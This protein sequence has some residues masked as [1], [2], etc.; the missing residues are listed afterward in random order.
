MALANTTVWEMRANGDATNGGGFYDRDP[1]TSVDYSQ[2]DAAELSLTDLACVAA[3]TTLTSATGGFTAAMAGNIV[4]I[5]SGT[6]ALVGWYEITAYSDTNTVTI[7][8]TCASGGD[9]SAASG[10]VGGAYAF[11]GSNEDSYIENCWCAGVASVVWIA[12]DGTHTLSQTVS[13]PFISNKGVSVYG[14]NTSRGDD[15]T[16]DNRPLLAMQTYSW[17]ANYLSMYMS[18]VRITGSANYLLSFMLTTSILYNCKITHTGLHSAVASTAFLLNCHIISSS[19]HAWYGAINACGFVSGCLIE[20]TSRLASSIGL[21]EVEGIT[22]CI[23]RG[24][25]TG[26]RGKQNGG[27]VI[28]GC[29]LYDN[30]N[31][32]LVAT[33]YSIIIRNS[34]SHT[35]TNFLTG[36]SNAGAKAVVDHCCVYNITNDEAANFTGTQYAINKVTSDPGLTEP[37][38]GDFSISTSSPAYKTGVDITD[39]IAGITI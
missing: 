34:I 19:N 31:S 21:R 38:N 30:T 10:K 15:P 27:S 6:N 14:Y 33:N 8:R 37:A 36:E 18:G 25:T 11:G 23:V 29:V 1:G 4:Y 26:V 22:G 35:G 9:M 39:H 5:A 24:F 16:G 17:T 20:Q 12:N 3:S 2:Q 32:V 13:L 28:E 7:D